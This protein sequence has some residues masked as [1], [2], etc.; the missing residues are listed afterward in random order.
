MAK[1]TTMTTTSVAMLH[2]ASRDSRDEG[3]EERSGSGN[4]SG[5][6]SRCHRRR[7]HR[8]R[9]H[10]RRRRRRRRLRHHLRRRHLRCHPRLLVHELLQPLPLRAR[11][12]LP[13]LQLELRL[14][15]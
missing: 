12:L 2:L 3:Q 8:R 6:R 1:N 7:H 4:R 9:R 13:A 10:R 15:G 5:G 11:R 14:L